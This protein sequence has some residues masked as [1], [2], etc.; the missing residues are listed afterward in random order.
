[1][2][3]ESAPADKTYISYTYTAEIFPGQTLTSY[4]RKL[5]GNT[6]PF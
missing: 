5:F 6:L 3:R 4:V 1:M 2:P